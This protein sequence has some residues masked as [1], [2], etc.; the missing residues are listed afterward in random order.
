[1][2]VI[3]QLIS[4]LSSLIAL[5]DRAYLYIISAFWSLSAKYGLSPGFAFAMNEFSNEKFT[6][7]IN[8]I[9]GFYPQLVALA[10]TISS[11]IF[12]FENSFV[13]TEEWKHHLIRSFLVFSLLIF[14]FD[15]IRGILYTENM[16][17]TEIW[18]KS[19]LQWNYLI[20]IVGNHFNLGVNLNLSQNENN[21]VEFFLLTALFSSVGTLFGVLM[22]RIAILL[23]LVVILPFLTVLLFV[24]RMD[25]YALRFWYMFIQLSVIPFLALI[26]LYLAAITYGDFPLQLALIASAALL[27]VLFITSSRVFSVGS[28]ISLLDAFSFQRFIYDSPVPQINSIVGNLQFDNGDKGDTGGLISSNGIVDWSRV[29]SR[30]LEYKRFG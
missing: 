21:L 13:V 2:I 28:F 19:G 1:M 8:D 6:E 4:I 29:Y 14:S 25:N 20:N 16:L 17:Y 10:M 9:T 27:P 22:L 5:L 11:I 24:R 23:I 12:L 15:I 3:S 26:P 7:L 30:D 18:N